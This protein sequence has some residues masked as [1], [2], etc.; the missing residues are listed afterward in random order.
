M[1]EDYADDVK[2]LALLSNSDK[3]SFKAITGKKVDVDNMISAE[4]PTTSVG[5]AAFL[6]VRAFSDED[7]GMYL[8]SSN[9][10]YANADKNSSVSA[11][12]RE[13]IDEGFVKIAILK[14]TKLTAEFMRDQIDTGK[15]TV[16][17]Y[18]QVSEVQDDA[19][20]NPLRELKQSEFIL[21]KLHDETGTHTIDDLN[22]MLEKSQS[23]LG[24]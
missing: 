3:N 9:A 13:I 12:F 4:N 17:E 23:I 8:R 1:V 19:S 6:S 18:N 11:V 15:I 24:V 20:L 10:R 21:K 14:T 22:K 7:H 2:Q 5:T 16:N